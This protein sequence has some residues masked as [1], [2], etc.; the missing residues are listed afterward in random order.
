[1]YFQVHPINGRPMKSH[2]PGMEPGG[3]LNVK[4]WFKQK[5]IKKRSLGIE[6]R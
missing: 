5:I 2:A 4:Y 6:N 3:A 1:M